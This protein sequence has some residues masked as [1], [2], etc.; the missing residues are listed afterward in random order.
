MPDWSYSAYKN[1]DFSALTHINIAFCNPNSRGELSCGIPDNEMQQIVEKAHAN[2]VKVLAALGGGGYGDPYRNLISSDANI[3]SLNEKIVT[4]CENHNLDGIDLDIEL[5]SSDSIWNNYG[6]WVKELR[7]ICD[8]RDWLLSTATAQWVAARVTPQTF[9]LFDYINVMAYDNDSQNSTSHSSYEFSVECMKYFNTVKSVPKAKLV[10]GVPFYGRG[11][12]SDGSLNWSIY[13]S[14]TDLI[15]QNADNFDKDYYNGIGYTGANTMRNKC[16]L[17]K[18]YG[19]IMIWEITLDAEGEYSLL[20][21]IKQEMLPTQ[22]EPE[23]P[24][25][26]QTDADDK[27]NTPWIVLGVTLGAVAVVAAV[28]VIVVVKKKRAK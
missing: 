9:A 26:D 10:L 2:N 22:E 13:V 24:V 4:Y 6:E 16:E 21:L 11:Y 28:C 5:D 14:F 20:G 7:S 19:G 12:N 23:P 1:I 15:K 18:E 17:A 27:N 25:P 8:E 3:Q